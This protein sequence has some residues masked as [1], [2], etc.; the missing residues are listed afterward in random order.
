[1]LVVQVNVPP[2]DFSWDSDSKLNR[3]LVTW[4]MKHLDMVS[5]SVSNSPTTAQTSEFGPNQTPGSIRAY[6]ALGNIDRF[7]S[8]RR[9]YLYRKTAKAPR[10]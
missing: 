7:T 1:M 5:R 6:R 9:N 10:P 8:V 2:S 4:H 3:P